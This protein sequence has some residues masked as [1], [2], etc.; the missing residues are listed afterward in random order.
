MSGSNRPP[1]ELGFGLA[2]QAL[3]RAVVVV[4]ENIVPLLVASLV[5]WLALPTLVLLGPATTA[6]YRV[7]FAAADERVVRVSDLRQAWR[8]AWPWSALLALSWLAVLV[9][10]L[11]NL[12][13]YQAVVGRSLS[14]SFGWPLLLIW[15]SLGFFLFPAAL[16]SNTRRT[17]S[18][19]RE[20]LRWVVVR[21][22]RTVGMWMLWIPVVVV[23]VYLPVL[24]V[25]L[26][27]VAA[28]WA[29]CI[30]RPFDPDAL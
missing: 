25:A 3:R 20:A 23:C 13:F 14:F 6:L 7:L 24:I 22:A 10:L 11:V 30:V 17:R 15:G 1:P 28:A 29:V 27:L 5:W 16:H 4:Y 26:P 9:M 21:P 18:A 2:W 19:Y 8:D 12:R